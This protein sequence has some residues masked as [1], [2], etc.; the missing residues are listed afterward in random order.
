MENKDRSI[1]RKNVGRALLS[2]AA[3]PLLPMWEL[4]RTSCKERV[5]H[6]HK[7][8]PDWQ[9]EWEQRVSSYIRQSFTFV[10]LPVAER[11]ERLQLESRLI[12]TVSTCRDCQPSQ[13]WLGASS[14]K[15][16]IRQSGLWQVNELYKE[17]LSPDELVVIEKLFGG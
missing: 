1:F 10:I 13:N 9:L 15:P 8:N 12:S 7:I 14:P 3:D 11:G 4:D 2:Q 17:C 16:R 5:A 6:K